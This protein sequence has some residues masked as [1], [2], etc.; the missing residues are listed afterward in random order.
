MKAGFHRKAK[1]TTPPRNDVSE[2][3]RKTPG[4][5]TEVNGGGTVKRILMAACIVTAPQRNRASGGNKNSTPHPAA[6]SKDDQWTY[7]KVASKRKPIQI[8]VARLQFHPDVNVGTLILK[9]SRIVKKASS[10]TNVEVLGN[11]SGEV[12]PN[13]IRSKMGIH[14][15]R[16]KWPAGART[17]PSD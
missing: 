11:W 2:T 8:R 1:V 10:Y 9:A 14:G 12:D 15:D 17:H 4:Y 7:S 6:I 13:S 16:L 3:N 5:L